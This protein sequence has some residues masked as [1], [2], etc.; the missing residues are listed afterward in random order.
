MCGE[1]VLILQC[2]KFYKLNSMVGVCD[3]VSMWFN[4]THPHSL[5]DT[6]V[7]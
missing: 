6:Y 7:Y 4:V 1:L 5:Q 3:S 2:A